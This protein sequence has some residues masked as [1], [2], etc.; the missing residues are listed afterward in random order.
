M[1]FIDRFNVRWRGKGLG[2]VYMTEWMTSQITKTEI[3]LKRAMTINICFERVKSE[4]PGGYS[5]YKYS[6]IERTTAWWKCQEKSHI[7][8]S[9]QNNHGICLYG[10]KS[11]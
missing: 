3:V 9:H 6:R 11:V 5:C 4:K 8:V 2:C 7:F 1:Q 10:G